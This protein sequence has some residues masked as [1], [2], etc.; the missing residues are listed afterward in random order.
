MGDLNF[1]VI[2]K[3][4]PRLDGIDKVTGSFKY[5][6]DL[7][8]PQMLHA[9]VLRSPYGHAKIVNIDTT[10]AESMPGVEVVLTSRDVTG[11]KF[12]EGKQDM[13]ILARDKVRFAGEPV[14]AVAAKDA[15]TAKK[16]IK[17]IKVDY[18]RLPLLMNA[19]E[20][21]EDK[22]TRIHE[23][24]ANNITLFKRVER[25]DVQA[26]FAEAHVTAEVTVSTPYQ[27]QAPM[28]P[29]ITIA[30]Q[31]RNKGI[32]LWSPNQCP[33]W[34]RSR[35]G[36]LFEIEMK[37]I[38]VIQVQCG[39]AFGGK[40][41]L[42]IEPI[43]MALALKTTQPV[44]LVNTREDDFLSTW[45]RVA[46]KVQMELGATEDGRIIAKRSKVICDN[47][48]YSSIAQGV[49]S[50][51]V[52][53]PD[54]VYRIKNIDNTGY[55]V[56]TNKVPTGMMR[57]FGNPQATFAQELC[58]EELAE[59]LGIDSVELRLKNAAESGDVTVHGW[60][61]NSCELKEC[62][63]QA[64]RRSD[65]HKKR[66]VKHTENEKAYGIGLA[67]CLHVAGNRGVYPSFDGSAAEVRIGVDGRVTILSGEGEIGCGTPT[68]FA[69]IAAEVLG[70]DIGQIEVPPVDSDYSPFGLGAYAS[71]VTVIGG[72]AVKAAAEDARSQLL[73][74]ASEIY[75]LN[76]KDLVIKD[77]KISGPAGEVGE[78]N[79][80]AT[81]A[82]YQ[83]GGSVIV[84]KGNFVPHNV[85]IADKNTTYGNISPSYCFE[86]QVAEVEVDLETGAVS[87][88]NFYA[89][90]DL[91]K[92]INPNCA[93][94]VLEGG[95]GNSVGFALTEESKWDHC[96]AASIQ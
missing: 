71:R 57:G 67:V 69:Q 62:I 63:K 75:A 93:E 74:I 58:V 9:K 41:P 42:T 90:H 35:L 54:N 5:P 12:G 95:I 16:A 37:N 64:V 19:E 55:L 89:S 92:V 91:G 39:G 66:Q 36:E 46:S 70:I 15:T 11:K 45:G 79:E 10:A 8:F 59:K 44:R 40:A 32:T 31:G 84:G 20:A 94:G 2:G 60:E 73:K 4:K 51:M 24:C 29:N 82:C 85:R 7:N 14:A 21:L 80:L 88:V 28:E 33:A 96:I 18:E 53:R 68:A 78:F 56:Y 81:Q 50:T 77:G 48:A 27:Y 65:Y 72:S 25:G 34:L 49:L 6:T 38:R 87:L 61:F 26:A 86:C 30:A 22:T 17:A 1:S 13:N 23:D 47:G 76:E 83:R 3:R 43:C 52:S